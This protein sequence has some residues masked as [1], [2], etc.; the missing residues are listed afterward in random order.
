M[1]ATIAAL[2]R[3]G[4][5]SAVELHAAEGSKLA[6]TAWNNR[7]YELSRLRVAMRTK[8]SRQFVYEL[9]APEVSYG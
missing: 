5:A 6:A 1:R 2:G 4:R 7:L 8:V 9:V 3:L